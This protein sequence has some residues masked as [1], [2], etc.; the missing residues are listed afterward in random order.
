MI[1]RGIVSLNSPP[2]VLADSGQ[3]I[4]GI[5]QR[6]GMFG[7]VTFNYEVG[8]VLHGSVSPVFCLKY[9]T[10]RLWGIVPTQ[11]PRVLP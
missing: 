11:D 5:V 10:K 2:V 8:A 3:V 9:T 4:H 6:E 1:C 7:V